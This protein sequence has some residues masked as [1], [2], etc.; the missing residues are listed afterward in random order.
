MIHHPLDDGQFA[1]AELPARD[2][3]MQAALDGDAVRDAE[4]SWS[5]DLFA[6]FAIFGCCVGN[7]VVSEMR[8]SP[9]KKMQIHLHLGLFGSLANVGQDSQVGCPPVIKHCNGRYTLYS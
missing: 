6:I 8:V 3:G 9:V 1:E 7:K 5:S 4:E 2:V